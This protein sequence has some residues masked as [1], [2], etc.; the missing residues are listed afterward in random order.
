MGLMRMYKRW[1]HSRGYG[2]HT[3]SGYAFVREVVHPGRRYRYYAYRT[4][5]R[6]ESGKL[7]N[8]LIYRIAAWA[9]PST[10]AIAASS[11][12]EA[13]AVARIVHAACSDT[14]VVDADS[15]EAD[16][17]ICTG[18][19]GA[20]PAQWRHG[21]FASRSHPAL[22][23]KTAAAHRGLIFRNR[24]GAIFISSP[25]PLQTIDLKF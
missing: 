11:A 5:P 21:I 24:R 20:L 25:A 8:R 15:P 12:E 13:A 19:R 22:A 3:P 23:A 6:L 10:V 9:A 4:L 17:V 7:S 1:R 16:L 18:A 14:A 2:V